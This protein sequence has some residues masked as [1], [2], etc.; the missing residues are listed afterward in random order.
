MELFDREIHNSPRKARWQFTMNVFRFMRW[1]Y[2]KDVD[3]FQPK[4]P[5]GMF[6]NYFKVSLR[7]MARNRLQSFFNVFGLAVG[8]AC[9]ILIMMHVK[10]QFKYDKHIDGLANIY[11]VVINNGGPYTPARLVKTMIADYPEVINGTRVN[12]TFEAVIKIEDNYI[13]QDGCLIADSTF[14]NVFPTEFLRGDPKTALNQANKVVLTKSLADKLFPEEDAMGKIINS[15]DEDYI[16]SAIVTDP[17]R[18]TSIPYKVII[19]IPWEYWATT[20]WWTGNNFYS[21]LRL[22]PQT[23]PKSLQ[24]K[25]PD[26]VERYIG[27][28]ILKNNPQY[29]S[30]EDYLADGRNHAFSLVRMQD[31]HLHHPRLS[32]GTSANYDNLII[33]SSIALFILIIA[34][35]NYI[36]MSTA[37]SSL[38]AK[39]IGMRKVLGSVRSLIAQQFMI[40]SYLIAGLSIV[41]GVVLAMLILPYFNTISQIEYQVSDIIN[42]ENFLWF[43]GIWIMVGLLAGAYP[44]NYLA[45]F[46]PI[47]ALRGESV[48]GGNTKLRSSLVVLQ[49]SI[50]L[51]LMVAT[52]IVYNQL[53]FMSERSL[54]VDADQVYVLSGGD[55]IS[56]NY[57]AFRQQLKSNSN[58]VDV[59]VSNSYP[60][61]F[62]GDWNYNTIEDNPRQI[63]PFNLFVEQHVK[64]V[65]GLS[66]KQGRFF[67]A[68][69]ATDT[70]KIVVNETLVK[71]LG[72]KDPIGQYLSRGSGER[73][74]V[75]GVIADFVTRSAKRGNYPMIMRYAPMESMYGGKYIS[76]KMSGN[77]MAA[78]DHTEDVWDQFL[79]GYPMD[80]LF[81]DDSFQRMYDGE[82]RFGLLFTGFSVLAVLIACMGLFSLATFVLERKKKEIALRKVMGA[83]IGQIFYGVSRY[84]ICLILFAAVIS[85]PLSYFLGEKWLEDYVERISIN[86]WLLIIPL[87]T[88]LTIALVTIS[89]QTY[90]SAVRN[91]VDALKEE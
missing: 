74:Q 45:S 8:I 43:I 46:K 68:T 54:G 2:I 41:S 90:R 80:G 42:F 16:V 58:V 34:C 36:N 27:P 25:F 83:A 91:P 5:F 11:R 37:K 87:I 53:Q 32:L 38:R 66:L 49:F 22:A 35:I 50:S 72:W 61:A 31:I 71:E 44:A 51:F 6:K 10:H 9:C 89:F 47:A 23:D 4:S 20:G 62:M 77:M 39:E 65:W 28:D 76:I 18:T 30:F 24:A 67:D 7:N 69:L 73:F 56:D 29:G 81:M 64:D 85:L 19:P 3:D 26:F 63:S 33:F 57:D 1:R 15:D 78:L 75:T 17:P 79:P 48:Q 59:A 86:G 13:K 88:I 70:A 82:R 40:E 55:N 12:G 52:F 21:Y 84:F 60:S 14:F